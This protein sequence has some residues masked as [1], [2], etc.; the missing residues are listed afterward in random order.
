MK[1]IRSLKHKLDALEEAL[2]K[3]GFTCDE[4]SIGTAYDAPKLLDKAVEAAV[5][6]ARNERDAALQKFDLGIVR[7]WSAETTA[8]ARQIVEGL[9]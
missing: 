6:A 8:E 7:V 5:K 1:K 3:L 2:T 4:D 9:L